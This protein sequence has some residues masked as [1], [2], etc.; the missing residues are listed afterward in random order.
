MLTRAGAAAAGLGEAAGV[1]AAGAPAD[2]IAIDLAGTRG[3]SISPTTPIS[4]LVYY[5]AGRD[6]IRMTMVAGEILYRDGRFTRH[7][8]AAAAAGAAEDIER[9]RHSV[10]V[11]QHADIE[12]LTQHIRRHYTAYDAEMTG[13]NDGWHPLALAGCL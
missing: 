10:D 9:A 3:A 7:D 4:D 12:A 11:A 1:L 13:R 8:H 2:L 5:R 6:H